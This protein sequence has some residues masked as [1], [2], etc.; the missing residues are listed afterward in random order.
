MYRTS[1]T[2]FHDAESRSNWCDYHIVSEQ[3]SLSDATID[4]NSA[5]HRMT[6]PMRGKWMIE[7]RDIDTNETVYEV[8]H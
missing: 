6:H 1:L 5:R 3:A 4:A 8:T 2:V 7:V